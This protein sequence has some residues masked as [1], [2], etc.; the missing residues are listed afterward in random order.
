MFTDV[1]KKIIECLNEDFITLLFDKNVYNMTSIKINPFFQVYN[2]PFNTPPFDKIKTEHFEPAFEEGIRLL[3]KEIHEIA[4]QKDAATFENTIVALERSGQLLNRVSSVFFNLLNAE[5]DDKLMDLSQ[6]ISPKLSESSNNI[7]LN[8]T[9]FE[10]VKQIYDLRLSLN[11]N[12]EDLRLLEETF[13]SFCKQGANLSKSDKET[14]RT[15]STEL[16][17]LTL[18]FEQ[19]ALKDKNRFELLLTKEEELEGLPESIRE[20][21]AMRAKDK[22]K[23]GWL[24]NLSAP[25]YIPFMRYSALRNLREQVYRAFMSIGNK[26]DEFDNKEIVRKI[27]NIRLKMAKLM[28]Y[29]SYADFKL[30]QTMAKTP[31][32]VYNLLDSLLKAYKPAAEKEFQTIQGFAIGVEQAEIKVM[33]WDWSYYSEKLKDICFN[34][35]DEMTRPYFE[36]EKVKAGVFGLATELYGITFKQNKDISVYHPEVE[37]YEVYDSDNS[38]LAIL[39]TDFHP[40]D[41]KQSGAWMSN[42]SEEYIDAEGTEHRPQIIIVMNFSRP[43]ENTP[44]LL[45]FDEVNTFLHEF[46]HAL[47]GMFAKGSYASLTGTNV[48]RDFVELPSQIMENFMTEKAF[49]DRFACHYKTGESIPEQ[50]V[51]NLI[52]SA[53][54]NIGYACCRQLSFGYLDMAWHTLGEVY[55]DDINRFEKSAWQQTVIVPEV[56]DALMSTSFGHIFSGGYAAGY[57]GYKWAEVLDADAFS[58]FKENGIFNKQTAASFRNEI[59]AKGDIEAPDVLYQRFRGQMPS[60]EAL[61]KRNGIDSKQ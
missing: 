10:R 49:L 39:Y 3:E 35:N 1:K 59:L 61:L 41:G 32:Q 24:F 9:L 42:L 55:E 6:K 23:T 11:L 44:S 60:I 33:P 21:A 57:Y 51:Q 7:Y 36:L 37:A 26:G 18:T 25:S 53:N 52:E 50:L 5:T 43:T 38:F 29:N 22:N 45:T 20:A 13:E 17:L 8:E 19:N 2:T 48:Y 40:R 16:S 28:G 46:G 47:H 4:N 27:V 54:F 58:R 31:D 15:L 12:Q 56:A 30:K 34:I 14:Y